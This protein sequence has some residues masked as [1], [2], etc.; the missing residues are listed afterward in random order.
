LYKWPTRWDELPVGGVIDKPGNSIYILTGS[1]RSS[2][3]VVDLSK[4]IKC[5]I[6]WVDCPDNSIIR[7]DNDYVD[8]DYDHC[9]GCGICAQV[10]PT[11]AIEMVEEES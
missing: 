7:L 1:W 8:I 6:C 3:P 9:K 11:N 2:K 10:C 4:C 5:L